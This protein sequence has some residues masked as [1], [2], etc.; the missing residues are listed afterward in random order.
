MMRTMRSCSQS[1]MEF[2]RRSNFLPLV[3]SFWVF[4]RR[5][6][7]LDGMTCAFLCRKW[8]AMTMGIAVSARRP[9]GLARVML[10]MV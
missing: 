3:D 1:G 4:S 6:S 10:E 8:M 5:N 9:N 7:V 2:M